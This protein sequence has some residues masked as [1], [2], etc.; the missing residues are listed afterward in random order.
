MLYTYYGDDFT[1]STD[2]LETL[3]QAG[4]PAVLFLALPTEEDLKQFPNAQAIGIA[5]DS[6]SRS[7]EWMTT[8]LPAIFRA[9]KSFGAPIFH[10]KTCSTFD[11]AP[12]IG[13]IGR[14][15]EI[16]ID[17]FHPRFVPIVVAAPHLGRYILFGKLFA[18]AGDEVYRIDQHP[19]MSR[20]PVT[21]MLEPDLRKH[22]AQQTALP[23][24]LVDIRNITQSALDEALSTNPAAIL[25]DGLDEAS[26]EATGQLLW[27]HAHR[28][29]LFAVG[30]SGLTQSLITAWPE[31]RSSSLK[32]SNLAPQQP[33]HTRQL[34]VL[35]GS[36]SPVTQSQIEWA[37]ANGFHG[38]PISPI[39]LINDSTTALNQTL[40]V[41]AAG[42]SPILYT[43]LGPLDST[44]QPHSKDLGEALGKLLRQII[45]RST[46]RRTLICGGD[47]SSHAIQQLPITALTWLGPVTPGAPLCRAHSPDPVF[48]YAEFILKGGQVGPPNFFETA[49][50]ANSA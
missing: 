32:P 10:Y 34:L 37:L 24:E 15:M 42:R 18:A 25:F 7:P 39:D 20:H 1:G 27:Q 38:I 30:S 33:T 41:I 23:I 4:I 26:L 29:T 12:H 6:R 40:E 31:P 22:L 35:S 28:Q 8:N 21:P 5:G 16:G 2:V 47:T 13:S 19:T 11:S 46:I 3:A 43:S 14:A 44:T 17:V 9:L 36:C 50:H 49:R 48:Q 45:T